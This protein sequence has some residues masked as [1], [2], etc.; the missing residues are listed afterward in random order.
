MFV[1]FPDPWWK[2]RHQHRMV[3]GDALRAKPLGLTIDFLGG[4][5]ARF[6]PDGKPATTRDDVLVCTP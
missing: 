5:V 3:V 6:T 1:H 4:R 2:K